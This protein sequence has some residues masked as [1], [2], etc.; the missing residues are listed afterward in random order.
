VKRILL[1]PATIA[2]SAWTFVYLLLCATG[3]RFSTRFLDFGWQLIP[4][5]TLRADPLGSVW[6]LHI[7]PP[8]WNLIVGAVLA[9][10]PMSD[11]VS[12]Q[13]VLFA[14]GVTG[15]ALL[16]SLLAHLFTQPILGAAIATVVM[17][18]PQVLAGAFTPTYDLPTTCGLIAA[19]WLVV[20]QPRSPR[21]T[22]ISLAAV[23]TAVVLTR[24]VFHPLWLVLLLVGSWWVVRRSVDRRTVVWTVGIPLVLIGGWM[25][26]NEVMFDRPT[27][28][29]WF[30]MNVQ[31][32]VVP[33]A[34]DDQLA[35]WAATG[36]ISEITAA[37]PSGFSSFST[38][39]P[40]VGECIA[41][42]DHP[43][44]ADPIR[45]GPDSLPNFNAECYLPIYDI[46]GDDALWVITNHPSLYLEGRWWAMRAWVMEAPPPESATSSIYDAFRP[47][48]RVA[49][50]GL[51]LTLPSIRLGELPWG[52]L[53]VPQHLSLL[54][55]LATV[56]VIMAGIRAVWRRLR[57]RASSPWIQ[58]EVVAGLIV[59]WNLAVGVLFELGEQFRFRAMTDPITMSIGI[60]LAWRLVSHV[61]GRPRAQGLAVS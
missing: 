60:W 42:H 24:T 16:A 8:L 11:S 6:H 14:F 3:Q 13:L 31:R 48:Y 5:E 59:G 18:D 49:E 40:Y 1:R 43:S 12:L 2:A 58:V 55:A 30:G 20:M 35:G 7:Q 51:P 46:A 10:S 4:T 19:L 33:I 47:V 21:F 27:L 32:A 38:Y 15:V 54:Q 26:K 34:T 57:R 25:V 56:L 37:Y 44:T 45:R 52:A 22:L 41:G 39:E 9:W 28:S 53:D 17:L 29:S 23:G 36:D 50:L 61:R